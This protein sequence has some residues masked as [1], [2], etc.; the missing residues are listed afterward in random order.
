PQA[1]GRGLRGRRVRAGTAPLVR[2]APR[3]PRPRRGSGR[4]TTPNAIAVRGLKKSYGATVAV[5]GISFDVARGET[6]G[7]LGP[8]GAGKSTTISVLV[9][10]IAA[11][12]GEARVE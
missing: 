10:A 6:F 5:D 7:L 3:R 8:N 1:G 2:A 9:G 11:D 12:S 4:V